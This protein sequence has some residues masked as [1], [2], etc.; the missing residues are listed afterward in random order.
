MQFPSRGLY[1]ITDNT[2]IKQDFFIETVEKA[3]IGGAKI[4][5]YRDKTH[6]QQRRFKQ[7]KALLKL[8]QKYNIPLLINDDVALA[9]QVE[10]NGVHLGKN[11]TDIS[12]ARAKLGNEAIIGVSCYNKLSLA[13]GAVN[14]GADYVAFG[15]FFQSRTKPE[16]I[17]CS[18]QLL[19]EARQ[20]LSCPIVAI[21][22]ITP[23]NANLVIKAGADY[24][25]V[26]HGL[27]GQTDVQTAAQAYSDSKTYNL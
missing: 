4:I 17:S 15:R 1:A 21:G 6:D 25:A 23:D 16:A 22:G 19:S 18:L 13:K 27:F 7:A 9:Q 11:D 12:I 5:Q 20:Q 10:A 8:C 26:I 24:V 2:L 3:I 14:S